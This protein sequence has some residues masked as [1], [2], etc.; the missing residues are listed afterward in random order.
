M[1]DEARFGYA[2]GPHSWKRFLFPPRVRLW[3][4]RRNGDGARRDRGGAARRHAARV[5]RRPLVRPARDRDPGSRLPRRP[6]RRPR[7]RRPARRRVRRRRQLLRAGRHLL[8]RL[9]GNR[10][11]R[12]DRLRPRAHRDPRRRAPLPRR[13]SGSERGAEVLAELPARPARPSD[14]DDAA[15]RRR[16]RGGS[17]MGRTMDDG[18]PARPARRQ[19][20]APALGRRRRP[21]P[22]LRQL[23]ARLP[24][25]LLLDGRGPHRPD[26]AST[27]SAGGPGTRASRSTTPTSTAAA[28]GRTTARATASG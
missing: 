4:A 6:L 1:T 3:Q 2:V 28:S 18:R 21:L 20:R 17:S 22:H 15:R 25:L 13:E 26:R 11:A 7:L 10:P 23:H 24:D 9:D 16:R 5:R 14:V 27:P 19:P 8:L 12:R